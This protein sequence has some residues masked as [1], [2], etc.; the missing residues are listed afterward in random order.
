MTKHELIQRMAS[1]AGISRRQAQAA[2][3]E[4]VSAITESLGSGDP[5]R[6]AGLGIWTVAE[7]PPRSGRNPKTGEAMRVPARRVPRFRPGQALREAVA[8]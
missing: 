1:A 5:V 2:L 6:V 7:R 4:A 3:D 8:V